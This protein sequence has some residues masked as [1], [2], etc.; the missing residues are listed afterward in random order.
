MKEKVSK[1]VRRITPSRIRE[2]SMRAA[3]YRE[4][5]SLGIGEPD[6]HTPPS[7]CRSALADAEAGATHYTP[8]RGDNEL[9]AALQEYMIRGRGIEMDQ[10]GIIVTHGGMGGLT[11]SLR[12]LLD[13]GE[14]AII[15]EPCFPTYPAQIELANAFPVYVP[16]DF[17]DGFVIRP[18]RIA[19]AVTSKSRLMLI[20]SPNNPTGAVLPGHVLDELA[21]IAVEKD[22][23]VVSDEVYDHLVYGGKHESIY[24]RP[25]MAERTI[26]VNSFS[27]TFAMTGWRIGFSFG[28]PWL[29]EEMM[30]VAMFFTS[31]PSSIGQRAALAAL[32]TD[33]RVFAAMEEAFETR[34]RFAWER[35]RKMPGIRINP[36]SGSF[37][38]F[39]SI[40]A[41]TVDDTSFAMDLV[42]EER[43]VVVPGSAFGPSGAGCIRISCTVD[44][45]ILSEA[46]D[47]IENFIRRRMS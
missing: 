36:A 10:S 21:R 20:N 11:A 43:V 14:E 39:P 30:K 2:M 5:I 3:R 19:A 32:N 15:P 12:T 4:V 26:V 38:L 42:D 16:T 8:T 34:C 37:Y 41:I 29:I 40:A 7:I 31:C 18:D 28:P 35:L 17:D 24:T 23:I 1:N 13:P 9:V 6:F 44:T 27:K 22:L 46:L 33:R 45:P 47:R 25:G